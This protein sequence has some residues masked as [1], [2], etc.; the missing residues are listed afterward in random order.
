MD[1]FLLVYIVQTF[2]DFPDD[3]TDIRLLHSSIFS[4][5]FEELSVRTKLNQEI[6][7]L[8]VFKVPV[9]GSHVSMAEIELDA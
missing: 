1:N 9:E 7:V 5:H 2:T 4:Q 8:F 3:R 6:N